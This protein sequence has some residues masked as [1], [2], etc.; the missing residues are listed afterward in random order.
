MAIVNPGYVRRGQ[1]HNG[2]KELKNFLFLEPDTSKNFE[3]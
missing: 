3:K 1:V 2:G